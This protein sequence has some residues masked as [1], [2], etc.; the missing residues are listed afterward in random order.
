VL[1][2]EPAPPTPLFAETRST[3]DVCAADSADNSV[4]VTE[5][6]PPVPAVT[7]RPWESIRLTSKRVR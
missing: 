4:L 2:T 1:V 7:T 6:A 5:P 3:N